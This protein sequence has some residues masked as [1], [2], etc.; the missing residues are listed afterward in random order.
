MKQGENGY[1]LIELMVAITIMV[2]AISAAGAAI[3]Q[4]TRNIGRNNDRITAVQQVHNAG[5]WISRDAQMADTVSIDDLILPD[6][7]ILRWTVWDEA[8]DPVYHS[9]RYF[10]AD[11]TDGIG[12]LE[13]NHWSSA[14]ANEQTL[15]AEYIYC[16][17][18]DTDDTSK[19]GYQDSLLTVQLTALFEDILESRE[20]RI[21]HRPTLE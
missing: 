13:R 16:D 10:F 8:G 20:Y 17:P 18:A 11:L 5:Y 7:L 12:K 1:T 4:I 3:Y 2:L 21:K 6:F 9:A 15:I 14:G 19:A